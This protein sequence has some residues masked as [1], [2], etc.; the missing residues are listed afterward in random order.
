MA[1]GTA[2]YDDAA[3]QLFRELGLDRL[4]GMPGNRLRAGCIYNPLDPIIK[5]GNAAI[6]VGNE[7]A[8]RSRSI[9]D[10]AGITHVVNCTE[11]IPNFHEAGACS[12][13]TASA[14]PLT[15]MRF[16]VSYWPQHVDMSHASV[17]AFAQQLFDF[18]DYAL[19]QGGSVLI[20]CLAGAHR[21]GTTG[22]LCLMRH[23]RLAPSD[24]IVLAKK[25]RPA[26]NPIG[27]LPELL[28]RYHL[29]MHASPSAYAQDT[30]AAVERSQAAQGSENKQVFQMSA[31][32]RR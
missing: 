10:A 30:K 26:I 20:H 7:Q 24:A 21:A 1:E 6:Y 8:A 22:V 4:G 27:G 29:A 14:I 17:L 11:N 3:H 9:L 23:H 32:G 28:Q 16:P 31:M 5:V 19:S 25:L 18:V 15:Y 2:Y 13:S 12:A